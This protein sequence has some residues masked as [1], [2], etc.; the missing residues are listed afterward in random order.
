[1]SMTTAATMATLLLMQTSPGG[2]NLPFRSRHL[3]A[4]RIL[5]AP[6]ATTR[7]PVSGMISLRVQHHRSPS[8]PALV[9]SILTRLSATSGPACFPVMTDVLREC[10]TL[11]QRGSRS[12]RHAIWLE[13]PSL[14]A[15]SCARPGVPQWCVR[16]GRLRWCRS[17]HVIR[18]TVRS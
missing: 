13:I 18:W 9:Y 14:L 2:V 11:H 17:P 8:F 4:L 7:P 1:M 16:P 3:R 10:K 6:S 15:Y 5:T 12:L